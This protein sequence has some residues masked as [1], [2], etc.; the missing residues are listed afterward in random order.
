MARITRTSSGMTYEAD[1]DEGT[2]WHNGQHIMRDHDGT[3]T[4]S[5]HHPVFN[6][7]GN[8]WA[9][10]KDYT[11]ANVW[12]VHQSGLHIVLDAWHKGPW[13]NKVLFPTLEIGIN[14]ALAAKATG[15]HRVM[16][17]ERECWLQKDV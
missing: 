11:S 2:V 8:G 4:S 17:N 5:R 12:W 15:F 3:S 10:L 13:E 7:I 6:K 14:A 1:T 16:Y 9:W